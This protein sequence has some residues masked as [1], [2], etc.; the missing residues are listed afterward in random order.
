MNWYSKR[1][2]LAGVISSTELFMLQDSSPQFKVFIKL[3]WFDFLFGWINFFLTF[4]WLDDLFIVID[5][6]VGCFNI[7]IIFRKPGN[8]WIEDLKILQ[9]SL[10]WGVFHREHW[11]TFSR[12]F[13]S[14][15]I[16]VIFH[17]EHWLTL[18]RIFFSDLIPVIFVY[19]VLISLYF[20]SY[21]H[22]ISK[23][24]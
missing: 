5:W 22:N 24:V 21:F 12:I 2:L 7:F 11:L 17:R 14:D 13:F 9:E 19:A 3:I 6:L 1:V 18:S 23:G 4:E 20:Y 10:S 8:F 15:L 16:P